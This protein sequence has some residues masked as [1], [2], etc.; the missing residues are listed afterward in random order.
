[1]T[2]AQPKPLS[3]RSNDCRTAARELLQ[4]PSE[5]LGDLGQ[6]RAHRPARQA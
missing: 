3:R 4:A 2:V 6:G 1:M 5:F